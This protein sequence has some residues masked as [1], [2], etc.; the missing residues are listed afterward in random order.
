[1]SMPV[2]PVKKSELVDYLTDEQQKLVGQTMERINEKLRT[3][4]AQGGAVSVP[5]DSLPKKVIDT[6]IREYRKDEN[7][8]VQE[9]QDNGSNQTDSFHI[10]VFN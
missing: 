8:K 6:L 2:E 10:L 9:K 7:W 4:W 5:I 1:M 3:E